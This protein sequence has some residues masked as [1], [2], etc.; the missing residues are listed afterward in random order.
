[1]DKDT[2]GSVVMAGS[3]YRWITVGARDPTSIDGTAGQYHSRLAAYALE[4]KHVVGRVEISKMEQIAPPF[5]YTRPTNTITEH[6]GMEGLVWFSFEFCNES[7]ELRVLGMD[8]NKEGS[9]GRL[10]FQGKF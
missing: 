2:T 1:L 9:R 8:K 6:T 7:R 3:K 10:V 5:I 4:L